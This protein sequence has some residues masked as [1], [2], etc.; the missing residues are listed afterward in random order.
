MLPRA[1]SGTRSMTLQELDQ[2]TVE[3]RR[4]FTR[5]GFQGKQLFEAVFLGCGEAKDCGRWRSLRSTHRDVIRW[6]STGRHMWVALDN[7]RGS[8]FQPRKL[9]VWDVAPGGRYSP[10]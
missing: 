9:P 7:S 3:H 4:I 2:M 6:K 8:L 5:S 10:V 1:E